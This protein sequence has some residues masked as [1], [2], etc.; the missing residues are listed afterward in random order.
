LH[1]SQRGTFLFL[2]FMNFH[3]YCLCCVFDAS[4]CAHYAD[5]WSDY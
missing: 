3:Y 1:F 2:V 5:S 4:V